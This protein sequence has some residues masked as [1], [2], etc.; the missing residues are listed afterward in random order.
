V[1]GG[2]SR[3]MRGKSCRVFAFIGKDSFDFKIRSLAKAKFT[4]ITLKSS[5]YAMGS[6]GWK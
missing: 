4:I 6:I 3:E 1:Q 5:F 2:E